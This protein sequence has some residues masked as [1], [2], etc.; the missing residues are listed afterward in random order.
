MVLPVQR[1]VQYYVAE[2]IEAM[3]TE[4][5]FIISGDPL[6]TNYANR[7]QV[8]EVANLAM[9]KYPPVT[10]EQLIN[11]T[12]WYHVKAVIF[13]YNLS[14][15]L[16]YIEYI[17]EHY[18]FYKAYDEKGMTSDIEGEIEIN[19]QTFTIYLRPET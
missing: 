16:D 2:D 6:I 8:P 7:L 4:D 12:E 10:P 15:Q 11:Y 17:Q 1:P 9:V 3:T 19:M 18:D 14:N 13:T 5:D